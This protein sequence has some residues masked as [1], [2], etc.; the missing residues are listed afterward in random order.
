M[1]S[2]VLVGLNVR[3]VND[4]SQ[5]GLYLPTVTFQTPWSMLLEFSC[6]KQWTFHEFICYF[7]HEFI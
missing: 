3:T 1:E 5:E 2:F 4:Q 6:P 7:A